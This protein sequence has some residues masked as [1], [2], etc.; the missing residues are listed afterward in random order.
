MS[1]DNTLTIA[2][3]V[4]LLVGIIAAGT[5]WQIWVA[6][7]VGGSVLTRRNLEAL[8]GAQR[9]RVATLARIAIRSLK[10]TGLRGLARQLEKAVLSDSKDN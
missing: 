9:R 2:V 8:H 5:I 3:I 1:W 4:I 7:K 10:F 6:R